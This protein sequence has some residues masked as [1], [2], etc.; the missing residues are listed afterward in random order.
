MLKIIII[1]AIELLAMNGLSKTIPTKVKIEASKDS[2]E[3]NCSL[4][5][6]ISISNQ[7]RPGPGPGIALNIKIITAVPTIV[8]LNSS[9]NSLISLNIKNRMIITEPIKTIS[10]ANCTLKDPTERVKITHTRGCS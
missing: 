10:C 3:K 5:P 6:N 1:F 8:S 9:G 7:V 2:I 4:N